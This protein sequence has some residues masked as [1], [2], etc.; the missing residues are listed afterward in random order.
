MT[1][2]LYLGNVGDVPL[3]AAV[4][5]LDVVA[6]VAALVGGGGGAVAG[7]AG[8]FVVGF[9]EVVGGE[10]AGLFGGRVVFQIFVGIGWWL[11]IGIV[12]F[13]L[14]FGLLKGAELILADER[15]AQFEATFS[16]NRLSSLVQ[17]VL[18]HSVSLVDVKTLTLPRR[19]V[20]VHRQQGAGDVG[21]GNVEFDFESVGRLG[22]DVDVGQEGRGEVVGVFFGDEVD[23]EEEGEEGER[24]AG[25]GADA[26]FGRDGRVGVEGPEVARVVG[27]PHG[28]GE[29]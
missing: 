2:L 17:A 22:H 20:G 8:E 25:K 7:A 18:P 27:G 10:L 6:G 1:T 9:G 29:N 13:L 26:E 4:G 11:L 3:P 21:E 23:G 24:G 19:I 15:V 28:H 16:S 14:F 12:I 5:P